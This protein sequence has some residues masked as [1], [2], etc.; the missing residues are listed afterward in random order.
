MWVGTLVLADLGLRNNNGLSSC[1]SSENALQASCSM[2]AAPG[3]TFIRTDQHVMPYVNVIEE[4]VLMFEHHLI[5]S[6]GNRLPTGIDLSQWLDI[7]QNQT[8]DDSAVMET[9]P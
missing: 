7:L 5:S 1:T 9:T 8:F 6:T 3:I 4:P 2:L